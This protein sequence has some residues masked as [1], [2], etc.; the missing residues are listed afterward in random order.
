MSET[1]ETCDQAISEGSDMSTCSRELADGPMQCDWL[2]GP[3]TVKSGPGARPAS[4]SV[5]LAPSVAARMSATYGLRSS[6]SSASAALQQSLASRL[7]ALLDSHGSTMFTLTWKAQVTPLRRPICALLASA[8]RTSGSGCTGWP[9]ATR[10]DS[11]RMPSKTF[12]TKNITL[13]HAAVLAGW[14]TTKA[15]DADKGVRTHRGAL[16]EL[17]RK[18]PGSDLPTM[19][20]AS[21]A[22]PAARD[23]KWANSI[24]HVTTNGSGRMH[25]GQLPNQAVHLI[26]GATPNGS[27]AA[28][29]KPGQLNPAFSLCFLMGYPVEW[30]LDAPS[31]RPQPR[32]RK[33]KRGICSAASAC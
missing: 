16:K 29:E 9:T 23:V 4:R 19:A 28:T 15:S 7:Q 21:W 24:E 8:P 30:L 18:G 31:S 25:M 17:G 20:A 5:P 10:Q 22:I 2:D 32:Y 13:N 26:S 11:V 33:P 1:L 3:M 14:P 27:N 12:T 6:T